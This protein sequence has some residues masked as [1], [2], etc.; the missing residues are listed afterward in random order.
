MRNEKLQR[1]L[2]MM[3]QQLEYERSTTSRTFPLVT[4]K[5]QSGPDV[6]R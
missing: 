5:S 6:D 3:G 4:P 2:E 1:Q